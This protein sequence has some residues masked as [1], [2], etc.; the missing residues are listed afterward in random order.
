MTATREVEI[1]GVGTLRI[2][3]EPLEDA[4]D[5]VRAEL[6]QAS[7]APAVLSRRQLRQLAARTR[8]DELTANPPPQHPAV[9]AAQAVRAARADMDTKAQAL[10]LAKSL[11]RLE[12]AKSLAATQMAF[13][14]SNAA[15]QDA[16]A[17]EASA[18]E[19]LV[20]DQAAAARERCDVD[21]SL[22]PALDAATVKAAA[23]AAARAAARTA[24][25]RAI[26]AADAA[27]AA[28]VKPAADAHAQAKAAHAA[29]L[30]A[31]AAVAPKGV[32]LPPVPAAIAASTGTSGGGKA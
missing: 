3:P 27:A 11:A 29:A 17:A 1:E 10:A 25:D 2:T 8:L 15:S 32:R 22:G 19:A 9:A 6:V 30:D 31:H 20:Q 5:H 18:R 26:G 12:R 4:P 7:P 16:T 28:S 21:P 13:I 23:A 24:L 14:A